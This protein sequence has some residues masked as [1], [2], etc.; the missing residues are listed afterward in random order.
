MYAYPM[1]SDNGY[2]LYYDKAVVSEASVENMT[3]IIADCK[4]ASKQ[5]AFQLGKDGAW[6]NASFFF[7]A[8]CVSEWST[9][10][11]GK[12][13]G[14]NDTY[15]SPNGLVALKGMQELITSGT[16]V[17]SSSADAFSSG[18]AALVTGTWAYK[19]ILK[20]F[21]DRPQDLGITDLP[22]Y[23]VDGNSYHLKSF[24]GY[25]LMGVKPQTSTR[26]AQAAHSL[27]NFL[28]AEAQQLTRFTSKGWGPSN[29]VAQE[30]DAVKADVALAALR[31]QNECSVVQG[32]YPDGWWN[33]AASMGDSIQQGSSLESI[34]ANYAAGLDALKNA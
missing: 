33:L 2:F 13:N 4:A 15:N 26:R 10:T 9:T 18:A 34:L 11:D 23:T 28:T 32:Q 3:S 20:I 8:G 12:F 1:T 30:N 22:S 24:A 16:Y 7:G 29:K 27:A 31:K 25:K 17:N 21:K 14:Y 19:D 5:F 6:Y